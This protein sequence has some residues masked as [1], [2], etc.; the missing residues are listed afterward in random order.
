[1]SNL[2]AISA[3]TVSHYIESI[4]ATLNIRNRAQ[5]TAAAVQLRLLD[6]D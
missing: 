3:N 4:Y 2:S 6:S 5:A 1:V